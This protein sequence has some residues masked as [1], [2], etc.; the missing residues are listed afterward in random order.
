M[1]NRNIVCNDAQLMF[2]ACFSAAHDGCAEQQQQ[3]QQES[4]RDGLRA[5]N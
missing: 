1:T 3:Q 2:W 5:N 4:E